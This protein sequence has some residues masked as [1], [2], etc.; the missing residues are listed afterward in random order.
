M[1]KQSYHNGSFWFD[2]MQIEPPVIPSALPES[3]DI[4]IVGAGYTGLWTAYYLSKLE[5]SL[6]IGIFEANSVGFGASGRNGGWC[7]GWATGIDQMLARPALRQKGLDV[8]RAM[9]AT[10]DEIETICTVE[11]IDCHFKKGGWVT[12]ARRGF[13]VERMQ[14][15]VQQFHEAGLS[16]E[17]FQWLDPD[18]TRARVNMTRNLGSIYTP[19]CASIHPA[20]LVRGL[21]A[22]VMQQGVHIYEQ[23]PVVAISNKAL[24]TNRGTVKA[25]IILRATEGYTDSIKGQTRELLPLY[26]MMVATEPL[27]EGIWDAIGLEERETFGDARR[28]T[29]YGQRTLDGRLAFGGRAGYYFG[30]KRIPVMQ[31]DDPAFQNVERTLR[32]LFPV[33]DGYEVTH[34]WGGLMGVPR[35][36]R[37]FVTFNEE[38]GVGKAG[39]YTGEGVAASNL[40][41]RIL[42]DLVLSRQTNISQ[43]AWVEDV[44]RKWEP[45]PLRWLGASAIQ[46]IGDRADRNEFRTDTPSKLWG[47]LFDL[48]VA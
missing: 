34:R 28:V 39:G 46:R 33:I 38:S 25:P 2:S 47:R 10:L 31:Q 9:Q 32:D 43:L 7:M 3:L 6:A 1:L 20:R 44:P 48:F 12:V 13:D 5:P 22:S 14:A 23:T 42:V 29:I 8:A 15:E 37:P 35:H 30:S 19:H 27:P 26:S 18:K 11:N 16:E 45:E 36:W 24:E 4:A 41:A 40:A 21:A 17:D